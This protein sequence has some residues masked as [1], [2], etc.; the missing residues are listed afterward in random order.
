MAKAIRLFAGH[1]SFGAEVQVVE[2]ADGQWFSRSYDSSHNKYGHRNGWSV[3]RPLESEPVHPTR[4]KNMTEAGDAPEYIQVS[5]ETRTKIIEWGFNY[6]YLVEGPH[7]LRL[8][9]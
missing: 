1:N 4:M 5:E 7:R 6:L 2:R 9:D 3:Y 8:P